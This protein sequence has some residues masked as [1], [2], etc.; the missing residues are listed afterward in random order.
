MNN[1]RGQTQGL[2]SDRTPAP[3]ARNEQDLSDQSRS[4][5]VLLVLGVGL[6]WLLLVLS[7]CFVII[8]ALFVSPFAGI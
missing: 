3:Y 6:S 5:I 8:R 2:M 7:V 1:A 4:D